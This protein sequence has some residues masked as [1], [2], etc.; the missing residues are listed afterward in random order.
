MAYDEFRPHSKDVCLRA[1]V[2]KC[3]RVEQGSS[4]A[5]VVVRVCWEEERRGARVCFGGG[6][7]AE[8]GE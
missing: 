3:Q 8:E 4:V 1:P 2:S 7:Q 6:R 5:V